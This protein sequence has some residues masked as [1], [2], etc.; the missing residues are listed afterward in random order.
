[1]R[2]PDPTAGLSRRLLWTLPWLALTTSPFPQGPPFATPPKPGFTPKRIVVFAQPGVEPGQVA[3][4]TN[5]VPIDSIPGTGIFVLQLPQPTPVHQF[6]GLVQALASAPSILLAEPDRR[7]FASESQGC[8]LPSAAGT[9]Q[10]TIGFVDG[11]PGPGGVLG[12]DW[13]KQIGAPETQALGQGGQPLVAVIDS[14]IDFD[15][16]AFAGKIHAD[17]WDFVLD[18]PVALDLDDGLDDDGD[19]LVDES[20]GH[21]THVAGTILLVNPDARI[22]PLRVV[23]ADGNGW[24]FDVAHAVWLA[25]LEG[26]DVINLSISTNEGSELMALALSFAVSLG[27]DVYT[28]AGNTGAGHVLFPGSL[29]HDE[30]PLLKVPAVF[31]H[32]VVT[33]AAVDGSDL[34]AGFSAWGSEVDLAAPG[35]NIF[36]AVPGGGYAYWSGTSMATAVASGAGSLV[37]SAQGAAGNGLSSGEHLILTAAPIDGSNP[38]YAGL[39]GGGRVDAAAAVEALTLP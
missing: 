28:S 23:D 3:A 36:S 11:D 24:A 37:L 34:K 32:G 14:G 33:V 38:D 15:H 12:Q 7:I 16:P 18:A 13:L 27:I 2:T 30:S 39:L 22:L 8:A 1:M 10:C 17:G 9:Q 19:G 35:T 6:E 31:P 5:T 25:T 20:Y 4:A 29:A 21:G 26:A